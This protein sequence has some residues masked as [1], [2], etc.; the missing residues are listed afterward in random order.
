MLIDAERDG[1]RKIT[2]TLAQKSDL[3]A[4]HIISHATDGA[5]QLG[6]TQLDFETLLKRAASVKKWGEALTENGDILIYGCDLAAT[7][8]GK[9]LVEALARLTGAD[10]AASED[11]TGA[12]AKGGDWELEF[13]TGAI[14]ATV[15]V[16]TAEQSAWN[17]VLAEPAYV[18][19]GVLSSGTGAVTPALPAVLQVG[20]VLLAVFE[21][22]G[23]E[24][25]TIANQAGGIWNLLANPNVDTGNN[26][27]RLSV[28]YSVYNGTQLAP[29]TT[30]P[31]NH[32]S[33][34]IAAF[35]GVDTTSP[36]N[37]TSQATGNSAAVTIPAAAT[38]VND[39]LVVMVGSSDDDGDTFGNWANA[40]LT[41]ITE[42]Y[43]QGHTAGQRGNI[44]MATGAMATAGAYGA[45]TSTLAGSS[46]WAGMTIAL[47][48]RTIS[49]TLF[50][51]VNADSTVSAPE[52]VFAGATVR[53]YQ[54][55]GNDVPD[56]ADGAAIQ[57][58]T[59]NASGAYTFTG[60]GTGT[61]WVVVDSKS[62]TLAAGALANGAA[63][64]NDIWADQTYAAANATALATG[65]AIRAVYYDGTA[66][67]FDSTSGAFYGGLIG[68][69]TD[70]GTTLNA[71]AAQ[72]AEHIQRVRVTGANV[73]G[74][75]SGFSFNVV[76][77]TRG[78]NTDFDTAAGA[79]RVQQGSLRQFI[80]N[81]NEIVGGNEMRFVPAV[82]ANSG[83]G[84]SWTI[85]ATS[86]LPI[87]TDASTTIDGTAYYNTTGVW[88][89]AGTTVRDSNVGAVG[90]GG[91][92][93]VDAIALAQ[94]NRP[95]L[96]ITDGAGLTYGLQ[97][98][99]GAN[100]SAVRNLSIFGFGNTGNTSSADIQVAGANGVSIDHNIIGA[101]AAGVDPGTVALGRS[102]GSAIRLD[103]ANGGFIQNN[104]IGYR[105]LCRGRGAQHL[106]QLADP[107]ER[108]PRR[109]ARST[110]LRLRRHQPR[111]RH[112]HHHPVEPDHRQP[113][114]RC[115][116]RQP[117]VHDDGREQHDQPQCARRRW[118]RA[119]RSARDQRP[120]HERQPRAPERHYQQPRRRRPGQ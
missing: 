66:H 19:N 58:V 17:H 96:E 108:D 12:A 54:D 36:I 31:G 69:R 53:L 60:V 118:H 106:G 57:T 2:D 11:P 90:T 68:G 73:A 119:L 81:A 29:T 92:V 110:Q 28:F 22:Q 76:T 23:D 93:G 38:T 61:Y 10:V 114:P 51:D 6:C 48:P 112:R 47:T 101:T 8:E 37:I 83:G 88:G 18:G 24:A 98:N 71:A 42:R 103:G 27:T 89:P 5:V 46:R 34:F 86:V 33:G 32:V 85:T 25:V 52:G 7:Q 49:G 107:V 30:D 109:R 39:T 113:G 13:K 9:S 44:S 102:D 3:D 70:D 80:L 65:G 116:S 1:I 55:D 72:G 99:A 115:R 62:I 94:V 50:N 16:S 26:S 79:L 35:R 56:A 100:G 95:E 120:R 15:A 104:L 21:S 77:N 84:T 111:L 14:E 117:V 59:T 78:D 67:Q 20:D 87:I 63:G 105:L 4:I 40:G 41:S 64:Q 74:V 45:S 97:L 75:D 91:T 82:A 43:E